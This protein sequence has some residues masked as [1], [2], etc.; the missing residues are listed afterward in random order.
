MAGGKHSWMTRRLG[1]AGRDE[2]FQQFGRRSANRARDDSRCI[3]NAHHPP[4]ASDTVISRQRAAVPK[5]NDAR[6]PST[7]SGIM[8]Q[9]HVRAPGKLR[10]LEWQ[11]MVANSYLA[12]PRRASC[13]GRSPADARQGRPC[14][15]WR[16]GSSPGGSFGAPAPLASS[17]PSWRGVV[18]VM[19]AVVGK[20]E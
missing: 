4:I 19:R 20:A 3:T 15:R 10:K 7:G 17:N 18:V 8:P 6:A 12:G 5:S 13:S 9:K 11:E 16:A 2:D 14:S 1:R